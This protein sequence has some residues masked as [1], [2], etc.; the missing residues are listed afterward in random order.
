MSDRTLVRRKLPA[1]LEILGRF[2][3]VYAPRNVGQG[4]AAYLPYS[5]GDAAAAEEATGCAGT[6]LPARKFLLPQTDD[7]CRFSVESGFREIPVEDGRRTIIFGV[8]ACE[9]H[10]LLLLDRV[11][12][13]TPADPRYQARRAMTAII[14]L[15]GLPRRDC[16]CHIVGTDHVDGGFD[17]FLYDLGEEYLVRIGTTLGDDIARAGGSLFGAVRETHIEAFGAAEQRRARLFSRD[18]A[19]QPAYLLELE[20]ESPVWAELAAG[21]LSC[22]V[23]AAVCPTCHCFDLA[24]LTD[25]DGTTGRRVRRWTSCMF[26]GDEDAGGPEKAPVP[27]DRPRADRLRADRLRARYLH[28]HV[29]FPRRYGRSACVGC[30][31]CATACPAGLGPGKVFAAMREGRGRT[32]AS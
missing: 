19:V 8:P 9:I 20:R 30:G 7:L 26:R 22:G 29:Y 14:G 28:K 15:S 18:V 3:G 5:A 16:F 6:M 10:A 17:L 23:C 32:G 4:Q 11:F 25:G 31:R 21:C 27:A 1:F 12:L 2:G 13:G 24:D